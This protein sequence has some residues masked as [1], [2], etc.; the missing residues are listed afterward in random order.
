MKAS[1]GS[2]LVNQSGKPYP[3]EEGKGGA[4]R[5]IPAFRLARSAKKNSV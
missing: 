1:A 3:S 2:G 4:L 5:R